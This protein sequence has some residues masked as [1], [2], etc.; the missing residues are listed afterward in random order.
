MT[1]RYDAVHVTT[2]PDPTRGSDTPTTF[3]WRGQT[4]TVKAVIGHWH[5]DPLLPPGPDNPP[6][7]RN[8]WRVRA[9]N[10]RPGRAT[11]ELLQEG[12]LW[13]LHRSWE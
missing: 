6:T 4:Y 5:E 1:P 7:G 2:T 3:Q 11:Y 9:S 13:R 10:G 12:P 8:V